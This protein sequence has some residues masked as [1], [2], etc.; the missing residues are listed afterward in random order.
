MAHKDPVT[1]SVA[2]AVNR[3]DK[4]CVGPRVG[5]SGS[6]GSQWGS[7][8]KVVLEIDHVNSSGFGKRGPSMEENLV[9][10]CGYHHRVKTESSKRWR[11][12]LNEYLEEF[13]K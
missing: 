5:M 10:L 2:G 11:A 3:R 8:G 7:G 6:C 13:Y 1:L 12:A 9:V 4:G